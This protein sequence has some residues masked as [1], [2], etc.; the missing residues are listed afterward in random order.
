MTMNDQRLENII[1]ALLR[2]GVALALSIVLIGGGKLII[3]RGRAPVD[4]S[5]FVGEPAELESLAGIVALAA[6]GDA[7]GLIQAGVLVLTATPIARVA[8]SIVAFA[9][10][11]DRLYVVISFAVLAMPIIGFF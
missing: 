7:C 4:R 5:M 10:E 9:L 8:F 3:E 6:R 2:T 1:A 11:R